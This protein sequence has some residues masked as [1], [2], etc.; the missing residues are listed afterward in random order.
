MGQYH[1]QPDVSSNTGGRERA[2]PLTS[3]VPSPLHSPQG[4]NVTATP[5]WTPPPATENIFSP[6]QV[7]HVLPQIPITTKHPVPQ[8]GIE[9]EDRPIYTNSFYTNVFL[10]EQNRPVWTHP[11][12]L[13]WGDRKGRKVDDG[14]I[15]SMGLCVGHTELGEFVYGEGRPAKVGV[16]LVPPSPY[17]QN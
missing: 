16:A 1:S 15:D 3:F 6:I 9:D 10:G 8:I 11:Y 2:R 5:Q 4:R 12:V 14:F 13:W 7:D 17:N